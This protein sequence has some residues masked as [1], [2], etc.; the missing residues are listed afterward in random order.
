[1]LDAL[2]RLV[3]ELRLVRSLKTHTPIYRVRIA[4]KDVVLAGPKDLGPPSRDHAKLPN[5]MSPAGIVM[6]YGALD[7]ETA[8][9]ETFSP[10][11]DEGCRK[12]VNVWVA[13]FETLR[14]LHVLD[15]SSLPCEPSIFDS[16][17][18]HLRG[19][20][21]F[22]HEFVNDLKQP[23]M[24]GDKNIDYI[25]TQIVAEYCRH[26]FRTT[27]GASLDGI[28]YPTSRH[29]LG[30]ACVL[31]L[32]GHDCGVPLNGF[33][34]SVCWPRKQVLWLCDGPELLDG[35]NSAAWLRSV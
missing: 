24:R 19:T 11:I 4:A 14:K 17:R 30:T 33:I 28:F 26:Q 3:N 20:I 23:V 27:S 21:P 18:R 13:R 10:D 16:T 22:L 25:P 5:R 6:F 12:N 31:F 2:G 7:R 15:L 9:V 34:E 1:M 32:D 35:A 29:G 8:L